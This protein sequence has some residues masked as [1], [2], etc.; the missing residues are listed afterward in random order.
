YLDAPPEVVFA[1]KGEGTIGSLEQRRKEYLAH[2]ST[3]ENSSWW[4]QGGPLN[5][6]RK[7]SSRQSARSPSRGSGARTFGRQRPMRPG[8][9]GRRIRS[10][11][12]GI[13]TRRRIRMPAVTGLLAVCLLFGG[14]AMT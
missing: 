2:S 4:M 14:S 5:R 7:T 13:A 12:P 3:A 9:Y 8:V 1:R 6:S 10:D 11:T